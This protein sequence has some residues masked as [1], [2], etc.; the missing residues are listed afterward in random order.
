MN[1]IIEYS[2]SLLEGFF[3]TITLGITSFLAALFFGLGA[4]FLSFSQSKTLRFTISSYTTIIRGIPDLVLIFL[5]FYGIQELLNWITGLI[6]T[7]NIFLTPFISGVITIGFYFGAFITETFRGA[8]LA[9]PKG[10][11]EASVALGMPKNHIYRRILFP[12][13][14]RFALPGLSNNW[15]VLLKTTALVSLIGL[16]DLVFM[17]NN[18]G[19]ATRLTFNFYMVASIGF[20]LF[21]SLSILVIRFLERRYSLG[22]STE[23]S[24]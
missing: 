4:A 5:F 8:I 3:L 16:Q 14:M 24:I 21:T 6:G 23:V 15:L 1:E 13:A 19:K 11:V 17:A 7:K 9:V 18:A 22:F 2:P 20:L 12:Q 10:Q